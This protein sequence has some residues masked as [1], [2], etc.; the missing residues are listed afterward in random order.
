M[1]EA[2]AAAVG[3]KMSRTGNEELVEIVLPDTGRLELRIKF[4]KALHMVDVPT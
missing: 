3:Q 2:E 4:D 1:D